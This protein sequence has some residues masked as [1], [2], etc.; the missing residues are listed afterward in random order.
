[1]KLKYIIAKIKFFLL[2][3]IA[4]AKHKPITT[5]FDVNNELIDVW[6]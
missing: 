6:I 1:M 2:V 4:A 3:P 5:K